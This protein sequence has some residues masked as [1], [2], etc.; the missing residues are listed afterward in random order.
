[1]ENVIGLNTFVKI[2]RIVGADNG[3]AGFLVTPAHVVLTLPVVAGKRNLVAGI[4]RTPRGVSLT[5]PGK[6]AQFE[7]TS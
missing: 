1:M 4:E 2:Q 3:V 5:N 7:V 6:G